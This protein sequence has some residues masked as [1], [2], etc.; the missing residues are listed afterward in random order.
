MLATD[1]VNE[2]DNEMEAVNEQGNTRKAYNVLKHLTKKTKAPPQGITKKANDKLITI[3]SPE[4]SAALW[5]KLV[6][7]NF[8][9][10]KTENEDREEM[11][12]TSPHLNATST[13]TYP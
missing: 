9:S 6:D 12:R 5:Q 11:S 4:E 7:E 10:T 3:T 13:L 1:W 2:C 8:D